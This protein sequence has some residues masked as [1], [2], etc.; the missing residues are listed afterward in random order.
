MGLKLQQLRICLRVPLL[1]RSSRRRAR[2]L[3]LVRLLKLNSFVKRF[4]EEGTLNPTV[5]RFVALISQ[6]WFVTLD[7][8]TS[9][10][11]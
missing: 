4:E 9:C 2:A 5:T 6:M 8:S 10:C 1:L 7:F 3:K 11:W